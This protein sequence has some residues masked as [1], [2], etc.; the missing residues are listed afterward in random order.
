MLLTLADYEQAAG[1]RMHRP[2]WDF[3][4][5]GAGDGGTVYANRR[6]FAGWRF[7]PR[8]AADVSA[9]DTSVKLFGRCWQAPIAIAPTALHELCTPDGELATAAAAAAVGLPLTV[10]TFASRTIEELAAASPQA[11]LWQQVYVFR[12]RSVTASLVDRAEAAGAGAVVVTV[13]SPWLGRRHRDLR[14]GFTMPPG[15]QARNLAASMRMEPDISSPAAHSAQTMDPA[16]TW[17]DIAWLCGLTSLPVV[18]KGVQTGEDALAARQAGAVAVIVSNHGGRQLEGA[19]ATLD[20]LPEV[21]A[22]V[23]PDFPVLMDGGIRSGRDVLV[24]LALGATAVLVGRPVLY[25]LIVAGTTGATAV[26]TTL[27]D[28]LIDAMGH[29]GRPTVDTIDSDL[30]TVAP[31]TRTTPPNRV[32]DTQYE[33]RRAT[34]TPDPSLRRNGKKVNGT[35]ELSVMSRTS[36]TAELSDAIG[37]RSGE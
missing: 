23:G 13:D 20:A 18:C 25:G 17:R 8:V 36:G 26:L 14:G 10:S 28:E 21:V 19:R 27:I 32:F 6:A 4:N 37:L 30:I 16:L 11:T 3:L 7:R 1:A 33:S 29:C 2:V 35:S 22:A 34:R 5:G 31:T 15:I 9:I 24:A 12:D